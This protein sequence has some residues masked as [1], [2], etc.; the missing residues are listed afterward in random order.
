[1]SNVWIKISEK[2]AARRLTA[3]LEGRA[4]L[5]AEVGGAR[6]KRSTTS[7]LEATIHRAQQG[8]QSHTHIAVGLFDLEDACN[9]VGIGILAKKMAAMEISDVLIRWVLAMLEGRN[10]C[11]KFGTWRSEAFQVCSGLP[12]GSPLSSVLFNIYTAD[13]VTYL[14]RT[15][16]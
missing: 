3:D 15:R 16:F 14:A 8:L 7:T 4:C 5:P 1:M 6:P 9:K 12:Q 10:C 2:L 13:I 11:M